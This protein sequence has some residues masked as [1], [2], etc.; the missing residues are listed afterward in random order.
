MRE[1]VKTCLPRYNFF[2]N[3]V[4]SNWNRLPEETI[5]AKSLNSFKAKLDVWMLNEKNETTAIAQ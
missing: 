3:R 5:N 4:V 1:Q 2:I